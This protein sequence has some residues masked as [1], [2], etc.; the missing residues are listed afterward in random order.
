MNDFYSE[1]VAEIGSMTQ[2]MRAQR[3]LAE[4]AIPTTV[5]KTNSSSNRGCVYGLSFICAQS[6]NVEHVLMNTGVKVRRWT[7]TT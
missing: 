1:C 6:D 7:K 3:I 2:S 4:S 5:I